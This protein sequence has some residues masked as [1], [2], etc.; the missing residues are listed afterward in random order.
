MKILKIRKKKGALKGDLDY[1]LTQK[2]SPQKCLP[3]AQHL[4]SPMVTSLLFHS[5]LDPQ[6]KNKALSLDEILTN[7]LLW[8]KQPRN[9]ELF[10]SS[11]PD[12]KKDSESSSLFLSRFFL[13]FFNE[14]LPG[15]VQREL[16]RQSQVPSAMLLS[17]TERQISNTLST[18]ILDSFWLS[19]K[20]ISADEQVVFQLHL[21]G[22]FPQ[23]I[24][25]LLLESEER[26]NEKIN[27]CKK[28]LGQSIAKEVA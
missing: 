6:T 24:S 22:L 28:L 23:E 3:R 27:N 4:L 26:V 10:Q 13:R 5:Q 14:N 16:R 25:K 19:L 2:F 17:S 18:H 7:F 12:I 8:M 21:E 20:D 9:Q 1:F 11:A 15:E